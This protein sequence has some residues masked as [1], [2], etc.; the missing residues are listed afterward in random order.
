MVQ[1][2]NFQM[3]EVASNIFNVLQNTS[4]F[5][6]LVSELTCILNV[7]QR[8]RELTTEAAHNISVADGKYFQAYR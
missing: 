7:V 4:D 3:S 6:I 1:L 2:R 8:E 5:F